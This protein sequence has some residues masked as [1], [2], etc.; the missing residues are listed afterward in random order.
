MS[1]DKNAEVRK[2]SEDILECASMAL[3]LVDE[4]L[5]WSLVQSGSLKLHLTKCKLSNLMSKV[6]KIVRGL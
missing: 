5:D 4:V 2:S 1:K 6:E 3:T